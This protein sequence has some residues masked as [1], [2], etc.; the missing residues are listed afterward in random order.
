[1]G[2]GVAYLKSVNDTFYDQIK[3]ADQKAAY[4]LTLT[5][6]LLVWSPDVRRLYLAAEIDRASAI[7][8]A[9]S[10]FVI[11]ALTV[12]LIGA[13]AV[14]APRRRRGGETMFWGAWPAARTEALALA[15]GGDDAQIIASYARNAENLAAICRS[16]YR[17]VSVAIWAL[18]VAVV[19][20]SL[21]VALR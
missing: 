18:I 6:L 10:L 1:M 16:K 4:I 17:F 19:A 9:L 15:H 8:I 13:L 11:V 7:N 5:V 3:I 21:A 12:A 20:H 2:N 14:I